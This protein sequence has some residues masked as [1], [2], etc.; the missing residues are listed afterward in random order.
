MTMFEHDCNHT[1]CEICGTRP[2][3][4]PSNVANLPPVRYGPPRVYHA[5]PNDCLDDCLA[6]LAYGDDTWVKSE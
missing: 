2:E 5:P 6:Y 1:D 3:L 4:G